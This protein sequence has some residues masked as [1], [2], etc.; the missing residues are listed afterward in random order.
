MD[1]TGLDLFVNWTKVDHPDFENVEVGGFKPYVL[2][3]PH[4]IENDSLFEKQLP[5]LIILSDK[6]PRLK[7][8]LKMNSKSNQIK[9]VIIYIEN[10]GEFP[11][12]TFMGERN[13]KP[14]PVILQYVGKSKLLSG[15]HRTRITSISANQTLEFRFLLNVE[16]KETIKF[17][18]LSENIFLDNKSVSV[19][20]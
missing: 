12:P 18:I 16:K 13:G 20:L 7:M 10:I 19:Q 15:K 9:E 3:Y 11:Y 5:Y 1:K 14:S 8:S 6:L 4:K 17:K 2:S